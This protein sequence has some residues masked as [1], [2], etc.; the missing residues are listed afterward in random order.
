MIRVA[1]LRLIFE[2]ETFEQRKFFM[3]LEGTWEEP[4]VRIYTSKIPNG[5]N[6]DR[7]GTMLSMLHGRWLA[8]SVTSGTLS[9]SHLTG[10]F[11]TIILT[12]ENSTSLFVSSHLALAPSQLLRCL[13]LWCPQV[14]SSALR[15]RTVVLERWVSP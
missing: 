9:A 5:I 11:V 14:C 2:S 13:R 12:F 7:C 15:G 1:G 8:H 4:G 3:I 10:L 6:F